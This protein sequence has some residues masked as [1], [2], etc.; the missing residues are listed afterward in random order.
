M[1]TYWLVLVVGLCGLTVSA[2]TE[3]AGSS[4]TSEHKLTS[5]RMCT[6]AVAK[7]ANNTNVSVVRTDSFDRYTA[8]WLEVGSDR[9]RW[10]WQ[11]TVEHTGPGTYFIQ[12]IRRV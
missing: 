9:R 10:Q 6:S 3:T 4:A 12:T 7:R 8:V 2:C 5:I 1:K 11:C